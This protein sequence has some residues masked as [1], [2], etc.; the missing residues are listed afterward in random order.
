M[1]TT[2]VK[3]SQVYFDTE[4]NQ[5]VMRLADGS[6]RV[7]QLVPTGNCWVEY[8]VTP[9][10]RKKSEDEA[11][12]RDEELQTA[13]KIRNAAEQPKKSWWRFGR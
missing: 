9:Q 1:K 7:V 6:F 12:A 5:P 10:E 2:T 3:V 4:R 11:K 8:W 13:A